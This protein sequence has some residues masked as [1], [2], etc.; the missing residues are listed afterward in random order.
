VLRHHTWR[1][2][3]AGEGACGRSSGGAV[4]DDRMHGGRRVRARSSASASRSMA[5]AAA[6]LDVPLHGARG[7]APCLSTSASMASDPRPRCLGLVPPAG[8]ATPALD[9]S[10]VL[11]PRPPP[12]RAWPRLRRR[13]GSGGRPGGGRQEDFNLRF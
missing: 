13:Q 5:R 3:A 8:D 12:P 10:Q 9:P 11:L 6:E 1:E 7:G 2:R 4:S